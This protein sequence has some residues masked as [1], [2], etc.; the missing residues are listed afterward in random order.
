LVID[1]YGFTATFAIGIVATV[2]ALI[3]TLMMPKKYKP[4]IVAQ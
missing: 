2:I 1:G 3:V 4:P